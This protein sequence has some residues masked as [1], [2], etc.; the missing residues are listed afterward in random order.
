MNKK[1][2]KRE[3]DLNDFLAKLKN[4][5]EFINTAMSHEDP[6]KY[7]ETHK[8]HYQDIIDYFRVS[9]K[10]MTFDIEAGDRENRY[11]RK[12]LEEGLDKGRDDYV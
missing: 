2:G 1:P 8:K 3:I 11:L 10:Y 6:K 4:L 5:E 7:L 9:F 12:M